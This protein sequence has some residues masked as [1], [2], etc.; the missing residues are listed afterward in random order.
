MAT[1]YVQV[2]IFIVTEKQV[3]KRLKSQMK[4]NAFHIQIWIWKNQIG[5]RL[6][7]QTTSN[8]F[9]FTLL[10]DISLNSD[11]P[12]SSSGQNQLKFQ[13]LAQISCHYL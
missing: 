13:D 4:E 12:S 8:I 2:Y 10:N 7:L 9:L 3:A 11:F 5:L 6:V 1:I